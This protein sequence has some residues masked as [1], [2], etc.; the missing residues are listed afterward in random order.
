MV[1]LMLLPDNRSISFLLS[2]S[3]FGSFDR[4]VAFHSFAKALSVDCRL[5]TLLALGLIYSIVVDD[6]IVVSV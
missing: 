5:S 2:S 1:L 3:L 6:L 4:V